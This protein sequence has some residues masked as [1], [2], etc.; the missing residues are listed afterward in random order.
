MLVFGMSRL[1][2]WLIECLCMAPLTPAVMVIRGFVFQP[3][4]LILLIS[5][6]YLSCLCVQACSGN[7]SWQ[8]VNSISCIVCVWEGVKGVVVF[9]GAPITHRMSGLSLAWHSQLVCG[10]VH[11]RSHL[12]M[13]CSWLV[14]LWVP[15]FVRV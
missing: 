8:Y 11:F 1:V 12:G 10:H 4:L 15:A 9:F 5:G 3:L 14:L 6:S 7:L 2:S 13:V